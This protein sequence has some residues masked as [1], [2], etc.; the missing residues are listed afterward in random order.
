[1]EADIVER[2]AVLEKMATHL[3]DKYQPSSGW[4]GSSK[5]HDG[6]DEDTQYKLHLTGIILHAYVNLCL[7][8]VDL[9]K[10]SFV[11]GA[12]FMRKSWVYFKEG[13]EFLEKQKNKGT[14]PAQRKSSFVVID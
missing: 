13:R 2:S 6:L 1:M 9:R 5:N 11:K 4:F 14:V 3:Y 12:Y 10:Q 8:V 7:A